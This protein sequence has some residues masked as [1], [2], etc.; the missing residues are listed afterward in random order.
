MT[1][2]PDFIEPPAG[3]E[4]QGEGSTPPWGEDFDP[5]RRGR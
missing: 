2:M 3:Q 5:R 1:V 4:P